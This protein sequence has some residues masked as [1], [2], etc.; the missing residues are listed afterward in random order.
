MRYSKLNCDYPL[1][2]CRKKRF[3]GRT[4]DSSVR[5]LVHAIVWADLASLFLL[6]YPT[7]DL[8]KGRGQLLSNSKIPYTSFK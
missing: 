6:H 1:E 7:R 2:R 8:Q 5:F 4:Y 3:R